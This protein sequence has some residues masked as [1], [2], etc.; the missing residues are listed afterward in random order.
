VLL[1]D[2]PIGVVLR[3]SNVGAPET[4]AGTALPWGGAPG[5]GSP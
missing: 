4:A 2:D 3:R 5:N 1:R